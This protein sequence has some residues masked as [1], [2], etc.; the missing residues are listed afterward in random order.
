MRKKKIT[1]TYLIILLI[2]SLDLEINWRAAIDSFVIISHFS[3]VH[4]V[5]YSFNE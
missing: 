3:N 2:N 4:F 5:V 1:F